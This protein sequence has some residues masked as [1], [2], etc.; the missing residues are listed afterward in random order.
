MLECTSLNEDR[1]ERRQSMSD[2]DLDSRVMEV[3][4]SMPSAL[5]LDHE[6][7]MAELSAFD[8]TENQKREL[9][10]TLW[11]IMSDFV[12]LGLSVNICEQVFENA[13]E[14][15]GRPDDGV[16]STHHM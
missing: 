7:Y 12:D 5:E 3:M 11:K 4:A 16:D 2:D 6:K 9:L 15:D 10:E 8:L 1:R 14:N 13:K